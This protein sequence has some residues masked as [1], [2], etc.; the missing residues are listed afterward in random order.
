M[1]VLLLGSY[2]DGTAAS[3]IFRRSPAM[4]RRSLPDPFTRVQAT[5]HDPDTFFIL[6]NTMNLCITYFL[7]VPMGISTSR[8]DSAQRN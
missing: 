2:V 3:I 7:S 4:C 1:F 8:S 5:E 6:P